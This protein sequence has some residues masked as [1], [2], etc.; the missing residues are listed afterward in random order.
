MG[1]G[2]KT[3]L[4]WLQRLGRA[5]SVRREAGTTTSTP[6]AGAAES[7]LGPQA[8]WPWPAA[9]PANF[10]VWKD[11]ATLLF[12]G[13][14]PSGMVVNHSLSLARLRLRSLPY[15]LTVLGHL[16]LRQCQRLKRIGN[17]LDVRGDLRIGGRCHEPPWWERWLAVEEDPPD[18]LRVLSR[19][20]QC[21]L[22]E[23][24]TNLRVRRDLWL[25]QCR[26]LV[27]L[28]DEIKVGRSIHLQ[29]CVSLASL[30]DH[31]VVPGDLTISAA[32]RLTRL[33]DRLRVVGN[34]RLIGVRLGRL[35]EGLRVGGDLL[36]EC[37][38]RL[39]SL[40]EDLAVGGSLVV[41]RCPI[42]RLPSGL[43]VGQDLKLDRLGRLESLPGGLDIPGR[44]ELTRCPSILRIPPG[45]RVGTDLIVRRCENVQEL[46][47]N[48]YVPKTLNLQGCTSINA[49]P[50]GLD[51]GRGLSS[52]F[53]PA[54][55]LADCTA[56]TSLPEDLAVGGPIDVAGSGVRDLP[57]RLFGSVRILWRGVV[58]PPEVIFRP[59]S[60]TPEQILGQ[61]NAELRRVMLE[62]VGLDRVLEVARAEIVDIDRDAGGIRRL[63]RIPLRD[64]VGRNRPRHYLHCRC[65]STGRD[66]LLRVPPE[67]QTCR[68]AAAWLAGFEDPDAYQP[69]LET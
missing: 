55:R 18:V 16:D 60:L 26:R 7:R 52:P 29:G 66:Y 14:A 50:K 49:L 48:L 27:R 65:P 15:R 57:A 47:E 5:A 19:D 17:G 42:D 24:P 30:P 53:V 39:D 12:S 2:F 45:L 11:L 61:P 63:V 4:A 20:G 40:P 6:K 31:L 25:A 8:D 67:T 44:L 56:L 9:T 41:R 21:P 22:T 35:P 23:L 38:P 59:E 1:P 3:L 33:P 46:P 13:L 69:I 62:R 37:C 54:L 68:Q 10:R 43:R 51:A 28:P 32:P 58:V 36:L 34:L 64:R